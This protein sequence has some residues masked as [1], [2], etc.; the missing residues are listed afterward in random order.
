[1]AWIPWNLAALELDP[2]DPLGTEVRAV[3]GRPR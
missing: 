1:M 3:L 2:H